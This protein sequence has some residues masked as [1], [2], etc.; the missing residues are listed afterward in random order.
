M[1]ESKSRGQWLAMQAPAIRFAAQASQ[2]RQALA[3]AGLDCDELKAAMSGLRVKA[4]YWR[5]AL[6]K[7]FELS[8]AEAGMSVKLVAEK[9]AKWWE[10]ADEQ[11]AGALN[12]DGFHAQSRAAE[13]AQ[14]S[15]MDQ[16]SKVMLADTPNWRDDPD[17]IGIIMDL[18]RDF[19]KWIKA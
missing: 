4:S 6:G 1:D 12:S 10:P 2:A 13:L 11:I 16:Y 8:P 15:A 9:Y 19:R 14:S 3:L 17:F 18:D 7:R 5:A